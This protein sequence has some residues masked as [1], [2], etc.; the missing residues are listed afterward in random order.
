V[1]ILEVNKLGMGFG[2]RTLFQDVS[3]R[4]LRGEH[5]GLVGSNGTGKSTFIEIITGQTQPDEGTIQWSK[6]ASVGYLGQHARLVAGLT[7]RDVLRTAFKGLFE[8]EEEM[9]RIGEAMATADP[10]EMEKLLEE[11]G[12]IQDHLETSGFYMIDAKIE[13]V[14][15]GLLSFFGK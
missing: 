4:L 11:M 2:A 14:A 1:S 12:D 8:L 15:K 3:F 7:V 5:V 9:G 6:H 10:D 13:E